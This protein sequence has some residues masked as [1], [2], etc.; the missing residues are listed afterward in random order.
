MPKLSGGFGVNFRMDSVSII[1]INVAVKRLYSAMDGFY[2]LPIERLFFN[3][4]IQ[5]NNYEKN[6]CVFSG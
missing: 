5:E 2:L 4:A 6:P 3:L 1:C